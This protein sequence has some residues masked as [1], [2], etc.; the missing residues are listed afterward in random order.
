M[1]VI[2]FLIVLTL[3]G[4]VRLLKKTGHLG[5]STTD[6]YIRYIS[7]IGEKTNC[8]GQNTYGYYMTNFLKEVNRKNM[9]KK[10]GVLDK[11]QVATPLKKLTVLTTDK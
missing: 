8:L 3:I 2:I 11:W 7:L 4:Q 10:L 5:Q 9:I 6:H 1:F